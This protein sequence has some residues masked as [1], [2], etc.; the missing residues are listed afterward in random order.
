MPVTYVPL[1]RILDERQLT[2]SELRISTGIAPNTI[3]RLRHNKE[4]S[5][6]ILGRICD[7][8]KCD[9]GDVLSYIPEERSNHTSHIGTFT[10]KNRRYLG[11]KYK[12]LPFISRVVRD[13]CHNVAII[14]VLAQL[15]PPFMIA[16]SSQMIFF[17]AIT[18]VI[19]LGSVT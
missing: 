7:F 16:V 5:L 10:I 15:L 1:W 8:L 18:F 6:S 11:N 17:T 14:R 19:S 3:T 9:Y 12:L 4:V 2:T 13:Y